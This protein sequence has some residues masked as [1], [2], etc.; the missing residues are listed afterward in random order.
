MKSL[1]I[2]MMLLFTAG[3]YAGELTQAEEEQAIRNVLAR[4]YEGWNAHDVD[5]MVSIYAEDI[6]HINVWGEWNK[7]KQAVRKDLAAIHSAS[8]RNSQRKPTI[9][10]IRILTPDVAVV[11]VSTVQESS[12]AIAGSTLGTYVL[13]KQNGQWLAVSF[14]NVAPQTPPYKR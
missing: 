10:K 2:V 4:F 6:D 12:S 3:S 1:V 14:T 5:E 11:Q 7:G 9:E 8:A 13:Q